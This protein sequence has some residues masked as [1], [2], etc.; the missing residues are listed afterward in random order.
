MC[1]LR[2]LRF[3]FFTLMS[4]RSKK[5][6]RRGW[7]FRWQCWQ[8]GAD[9]VSPRAV[10]LAR[11]CIN[12]SVGCGWLGEGD[13]YGPLLSLWTLYCIGSKFSLLSPLFGTS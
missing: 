13:R 8:I 6:E 9:L 11:G 3:F 2:V 10:R 4:T 7:P 5:P 12:Y 1:S